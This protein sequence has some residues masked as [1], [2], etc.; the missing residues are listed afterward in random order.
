MTRRPVLNGAS[1]RPSSRSLLAALVLPFILSVGGLSSTALAV[2]PVPAA[3]L[4]AATPTVDH[5]LNGLNETLNFETRSAKF[6]MTVVNPRRTKVYVLQSFSRGLEE[7][8]I[9]YLEPARERGTRY[10]RRADEMW[11]YLPSIER[12]Q[13]IS[14]HMLRQGMA[15]SDM[16]YEDMT[17]STDWSDDYSGEVGE[18]VQIEGRDHWK[19][20]LTAKNED[21]TYARRV[22]LVDA[23]T[24]I[25]TQQELYALS[26]MLVKTWTM[27]DVRALEDGRQYPF[28][29]RITDK[30]RKGTYTQIETVEMTL[31]VEIE[32]EV[33]SV[34]WLERK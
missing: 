19:V 25:P 10:L 29:M 15:G 3:D 24:L 23:E 33:F 5:L 12:T 30:L 26:G 13:K 14:G 4:P 16:S 20:E 1:P 18:K 21:V 2:T 8:V 32:E 11:M 28:T 22:I 17:S 9:E 7:S 27:S 6:R 31:G 34:R